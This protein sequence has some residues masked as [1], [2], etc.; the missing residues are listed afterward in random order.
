MKQ[1][2]RDLFTGTTAIVMMPDDLF[3]TGHT[4]DIPSLKC[5]GVGPIFDETRY[6]PKCGKR[7]L[8]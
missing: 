3:D 7:I 2:L 4:F 5:C 6:C 1:K 8:R